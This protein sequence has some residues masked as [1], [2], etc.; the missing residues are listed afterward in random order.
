M[1][2]TQQTCI[3]PGPSDALFFLDTTDHLSV[4]E[5]AICWTKQA[6]LVLDTTDHLLDLDKTGPVGP[7]HNLPFVGPG[8]NRP[9]LNCS[10]Q[11]LLV[12][13]CRE[14]AHPPWSLDSHGHCPMSRVSLM[15]MSVEQLSVSA[16]VYSPVSL[17][18]FPQFLCP[19]H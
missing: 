19:M 10:Q 11:N 2:I 17:Q 4:P 13:T 14:M 18:V 3:G 15:L 6:L 1:W 8:S 16:L 12:L 5:C 7:R 9:C